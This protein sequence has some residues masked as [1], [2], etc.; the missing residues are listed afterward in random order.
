MDVSGGTHSLIEKIH[1]DYPPE[2]TTKK[3]SEEGLRKKVIA[4]ISIVYD[5]TGAAKPGHKKVWGG[6]GEID[7]YYEK[8]AEKVAIETKIDEATVLDVY[9][10]LMY[11]DGLVHEGIKPSKGILIAA[12][13]PAWVQAAIDN[14][15]QLSTNRIV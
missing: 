5:L 7:V 1:D 6:G 11:W 9:Q 8:N 3:Q 15:N 12:A 4:K 13:F 2:K 10:L 14:I